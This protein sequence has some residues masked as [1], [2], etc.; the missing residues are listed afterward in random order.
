MNKLKKEL[1]LNLCVV[2]LIVSLLYSFLLVNVN[3]SLVSGDTSY[4]DPGDAVVFVLF[5]LI[6]YIPH[7]VFSLISYTIMKNVRWTLTKKLFTQ[8]VIGLV[9]IAIVY[10]LINE[11][12]VF[13]LVF[14]LIV[15]SLGSINNMRK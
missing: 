10:F 6:L 11:P 3:N 1:I 5:F 13:F 8:N 2:S 4:S 9:M 12:I 7:L 15:Y 14:S